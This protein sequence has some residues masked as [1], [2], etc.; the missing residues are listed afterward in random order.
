MSS[1]DRVVD[2]KIWL[3]VFIKVPL[4]QHFRIHSNLIRRLP[5]TS[6]PHCKAE[7]LIFTSYLSTWMI[8]FSGK[9]QGKTEVAIKT[10]KPG[11]MDPKAF[12]AEAQIMKQCR[13][14]KLVT[15]YAVCSQEEPIYIITE[16]M[17]NGSL[18]TYL[19]EGAGRYLKLP[20]LVDMAA[21]V[22]RPSFYFRSDGKNSVFL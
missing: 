9:W 18:L 6:C 15:L 7:I 19:R 12:L 16:L 5:V 17:V 2:L 20:P 21:Q 11:T 14:E 4:H 10:M 13:H 8:R 1:E 3:P 22:G